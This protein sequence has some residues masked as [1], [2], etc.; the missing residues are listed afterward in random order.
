MPAMSQNVVLFVKFMSELFWI[1]NVSVS[2]VIGVPWI[3]TGTF[4]GPQVC[5]NQVSEHRIS[6]KCPNL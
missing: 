5:Y 1:L 4:Y 2:K 3:H 6:P